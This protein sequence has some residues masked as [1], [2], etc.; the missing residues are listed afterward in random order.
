MVGGQQTVENLEKLNDVLGSL[1]PLE[2]YL[3]QYQKKNDAKIT[4]EQPKTPPP[5]FV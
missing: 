4:W 1:Q 3:S 5:S 2:G